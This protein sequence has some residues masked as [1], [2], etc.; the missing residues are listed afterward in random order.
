MQ[1]EEADLWENRNLDENRKKQIS[2]QKTTKTTIK[3]RETFHMVADFL[4]L[5]DWLVG[6]LEMR[7]S[8][9]RQ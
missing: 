3:M 6:L 7:T 5:S 9:N 4:W 1:N 8:G 2:K